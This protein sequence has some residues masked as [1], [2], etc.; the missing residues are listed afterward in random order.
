MR[1][2]RMDNDLVGGRVIGWLMVEM[3]MEK[4]LKSRVNPFVQ[5]RT[6]VAWNMIED[7]G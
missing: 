2:A 3:E 4:V 5:A 7:G 6:V 1:C